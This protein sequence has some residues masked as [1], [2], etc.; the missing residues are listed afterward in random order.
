MVWQCRWFFNW[1]LQGS[2]SKK[3]CWNMEIMTNVCN[4]S[5]FR[6]LILVIL[7]KQDG[8]NLI[9]IVKCFYAFISI[10]IEFPIFLKILPIELIVR[11]EP[12]SMHTHSTSDLIWTLTSFL[13]YFLS[14]W[15][16]IQSPSSS[17]SNGIHKFLIWYG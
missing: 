10:L 1:V 3:V 2:Q 5:G 4:A 17:V 7:L 15:N 14:I 9:L 16:S 12:S 11:S 6:Q 8:C 13:S